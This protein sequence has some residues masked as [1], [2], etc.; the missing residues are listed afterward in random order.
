MEASQWW[1]VPVPQSLISAVSHDPG[2]RHLYMVLS[3]QADGAESVSVSTHELARMCRIS[4]MTLRLHIAE[5]EQGGWLSVEQGTGRRSTRFR[6]KGLTAETVP[7][8]SS[9]GTVRIPATLIGEAPLSPR[10]QCLYATMLTLRGKD[11][12]VVMPR[13]N[14]VSLAGLG[15]DNLVRDALRQLTAKGWLRVARDAKSRNY[16]YEPLDPHLVARKTLQHH[17]EM[18]LTDA[19]FLGE[20]LLQYMLTVLVDDDDYIDN[21]RPKIL[22]NPYTG[23]PMEFDRWYRTA[24]VAFE[25]NGPQHERPTPAFPDADEV[26]KQQGRDLINAA[27]ATKHE[28]ELIVITPKEL[29]FAQLVQKIGSLLPLRKLRL[30]DPLVDFLASTARRYVRNLRRRKY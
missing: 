4:R 23:E 19:K 22:T 18:R 21:S 20:K 26:K 13:L 11:T 1:T 12:A 2:S 15:S 3:Y 5:L 24:G 27:L 17:V 29:T 10:A 16:T 7:S 8:G 30:E 14:L 25:F 28:I 6:L 9:P